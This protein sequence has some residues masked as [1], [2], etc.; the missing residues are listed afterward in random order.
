MRR[1]ASRR[2]SREASRRDR[3][4]SRDGRKASRERHADITIS[5]APVSLASLTRT[6]FTNAAVLDAQRGELLGDQAVLVED[7]RIVEVGDTAQI[8]ASEEDRS[9]DLGGRT[10]MPG[11]ID[12]HVHVT[13]ASANL[14]SQSEW[15]PMYLAARASVILAREVE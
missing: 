9:F 8:R 11:L 2:A 3:K 7:E 14:A 1:G 4:A 5:G 13:A 10:L 12:C 15:S 6:L